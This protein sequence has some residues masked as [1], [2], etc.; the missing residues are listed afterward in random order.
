MQPPLP[1]NTTS[2][3]HRNQF[4]VHLHLL[5]YGHNSRSKKHPSLIGGVPSLPYDLSRDGVGIVR[6]RTAVPLME[7]STNGTCQCWDGV[8]SMK[9]CLH[10]I[11]TRDRLN[12]VYILVNHLSRASPNYA[13]DLALDAGLHHTLCHPASVSQV[14]C[15]HMSFMVLSLTS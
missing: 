9:D 4:V 10:I 6:A 3:V 2:R 12:L 1:L 13:P 5:S 11:S 14:S 8:T 15:G 7:A